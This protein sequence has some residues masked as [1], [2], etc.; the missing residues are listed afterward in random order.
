MRSQTF[1]F[2]IAFTNVNGLSKAFYISS[3]KVLQG[4]SQKR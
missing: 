2:V 1:I 4:V 3:S